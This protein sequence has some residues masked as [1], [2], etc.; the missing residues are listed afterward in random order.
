MNPRDASGAFPGRPSLRRRGRSGLFAAWTTLGVVLCAAPA[1]S[2]DGAAHKIVPPED[3]GYR[4]HATRI[5]SRSS[6]EV[7][8]FDPRSDTPATVSYRVSRDGEVRI[9]LVRRDDPEFVLR[10]LQDW[11]PSHYGPTYEAR[12]DGNDASGNPVDNDGLFVLFQAKDGAKT[13]AHLSHD[14]ERCRDFEVVISQPAPKSTF[15][16]GEVIGVVARRA[17]ARTSR[18]TRARL[19]VGFTLVEEKTFAPGVEKLSFD[20]EG[21]PVGEHTLR[22]RLDDLQDHALP[23]AE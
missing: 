23:A 22:L 5:L 21:M 8:S 10:T 14:R 3:R 1:A 7:T 20:V 4:G 19:Y 6:S 2:Q 12:W 16:S 15:T 17:R 9:R 13:R 11:T 18:R